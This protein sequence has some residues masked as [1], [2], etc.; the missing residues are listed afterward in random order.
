L[1]ERQQVPPEK[2]S[3]IY[4]GISIQAVR[5][6]AAAQPVR[7]FRQACGLEDE[8]I[9]IAG[10]GFADWRKGPDLFVQLAALMRHCMGDRKKLLFLWIGLLPDDE[11]GKILLH[12]VQQLGLSGLV[13]F[14]GEQS[15]PYPYLNLCDVFCLCSREDPF[16]LVMLEAAALAKP[17]VCF[18]KAGGASEFCA[19]GG[20]FAVP[21]LNLEAMCQRLAQLVEDGGLRRQAGEAAARLVRNEF[22]LGMVAPQILQLIDR[23]SREPEPIPEPPPPPPTRMQRFM[24]LGRSLAGRFRPAQEGVESDG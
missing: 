6:G 5:E 10:C 12:D 17:M 9:V 22:D 20:G 16:P 4:E 3:T 24:N 23:F 19:K 11:R 1:R 15:N 13:R 18:D 21:Y 2:I 14:V 7:E 8:T